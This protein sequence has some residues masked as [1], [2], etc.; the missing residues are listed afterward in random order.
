[1]KKVMQLCLLLITLVANANSPKS[2]L[3]DGTISGRVLDASLNQPL[4]YVNILVT[5]TQ[6]NTITGGITNDDGTFKIEK[7]PEGDINSIHTIYRI[8]RLFRKTIINWFKATIKI[9]L[10]R[11]QTRRRS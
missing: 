5:D 11:H 8:T 4:P 3:R 10:R 7:I 6:K 9:D 1:M 2:E